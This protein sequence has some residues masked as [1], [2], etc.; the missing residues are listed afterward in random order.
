M[1]ITKTWFKK[2][3]EI[4]PEE[5]M[6]IETGTNPNWGLYRWLVGFLKSF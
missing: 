6:K 1:R 4:T 2:E 3:I 5:M